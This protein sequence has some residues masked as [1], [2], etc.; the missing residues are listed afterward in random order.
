MSRKQSWTE[1]SSDATTT[2]L[3]SADGDYL[4]RVGVASAPKGR[5]ADG[6]AYKR[7]SVHAIDARGNERFVDS[8]VRALKQLPAALELAQELAAVHRRGRRFAAFAPDATDA[9][10]VEAPTAEAVDP[11]LQRLEA[12]FG[13][14]V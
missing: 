8:R 12:A 13:L 3:R 7:V 11:E 5:K 9:P 10:A 6:T 14:T 4:I 1:T 2:E